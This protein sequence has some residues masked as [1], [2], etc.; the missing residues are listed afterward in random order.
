MVEEENV[1]AA[2]CY[3]L[4]VYNYT[5]QAMVFCMTWSEAYL[6]LVLRQANTSPSLSI[7]S[8]LIGL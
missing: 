5:D 3:F 6:E 1:V 8:M 7:R 2:E 4:S